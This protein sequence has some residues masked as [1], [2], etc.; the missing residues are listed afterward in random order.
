M[1]AKKM[2]VFLMGRPDVHMSFTWEMGDID[3][4][5]T[6]RNTTNTIALCKLLHHVY[7]RV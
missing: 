2:L 7:H 3:S 1:L 5:L 6:V 4:F